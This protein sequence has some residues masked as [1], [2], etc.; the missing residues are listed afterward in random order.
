MYKFSTYIQNQI[1]HKC[2]ENCL[3]LDTISFLGGGA[4][5]CG[6]ISLFALD[7]TKMKN[8]T[9]FSNWNRSCG[10]IFA[11]F[12]SAI[13]HL[14]PVNDNGCLLPVHYTVYTEPPIRLFFWSCFKGTVSR[15]GF[16]FQWHVLLVLGLKRLQGHCL[17]GPKH[18]Q[19]ESGI[20]YT[21]QRHMIRCLRGLRKNSFLLRLGPIFAFLYF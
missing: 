9:I 1:S 14:F 7:Y 18:D 2:F 13:F 6:A 11:I 3:P 8:L 19:V 5:L 16:G 17:K 20:F 4:D 21:N 12:S 10:H 15:D